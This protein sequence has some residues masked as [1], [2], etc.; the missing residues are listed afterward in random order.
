[1]SDKPAQSR[2]L[3]APLIDASYPALKAGAMSG[4]LYSAFAKSGPENLNVLGMRSVS[5]AAA[6]DESVRLTESRVEALRS[7]PSP[8]ALIALKSNKPLEERLFDATANVKILTSQV[9][10][11]LDREWRDKLFQQLDSMHDPAEWESDDEPI[12]QASF[13]TFLKAIVQL[14]PQRRPG[15][16]LSYGGHLLAAWTKG[17]DR[18]T[19]EFLSK[20]R[21]K[22]VLSRHREEEIERFAGQMVV[23]R[24]AA[25]LAPYDPDYWFSV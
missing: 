15:L 25:A 9:A 1:M 22:W 18:L 19:V 10:M 14:K 16:G 4:A 24:L 21:V 11:H 5:N 17:S 20:D 7:P 12:K 6:F 23:S 8:A 3:S 2:L 13:A